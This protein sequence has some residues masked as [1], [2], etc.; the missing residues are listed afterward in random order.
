MTNHPIKLASHMRK[1]MHIRLQT[2]GNGWRIRQNH[3]ADI[4]VILPMGED[5]AVLALG[6]AGAADAAYLHCAY[7][8]E[9]SA[10][11][12]WRPLRSGCRNESASLERLWNL[13]VNGR[14]KA[15]PEWTVSTDRMSWTSE[16]WGL[17][18][19]VEERSGQ[20]KIQ[21]E[22]DGY[23]LAEAWSARA[24]RRGNKKPNLLFAPPVLFRCPTDAMQALIATE[25]GWSALDWA[26]LP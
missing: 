23:S 15:F 1:G 24:H 7:L 18:N 9:Y 5:W 3:C 8:A 2:N 26:E 6:Y 16:E 21:R 20:W 4:G 17:I 14:C 13:H 19:L 12:S 10:T 22:R 11:P 25:A